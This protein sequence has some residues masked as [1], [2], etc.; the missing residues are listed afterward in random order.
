MFTLEVRGPQ[1]VDEI[2]KLL[3]EAGMYLLFTILRFSNLESSLI[4]DVSRL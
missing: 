3:T 1:H 4:T 2:L